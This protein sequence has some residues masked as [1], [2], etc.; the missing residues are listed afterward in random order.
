MRKGVNNQYD[1]VNVQNDNHCHYCSLLP[2]CT[3]LL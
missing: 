3:K 2:T 1:D